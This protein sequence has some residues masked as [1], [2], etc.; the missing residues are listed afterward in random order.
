M[1][2]QQYINESARSKEIRNIYKIPKLL[3][4][5]FSQAWK[6]LMNDQAIYRA[7]VY[8]N[9]EFVIT[10]PRKKGVEKR[11]SPWASK[12]FYNLLLNNLPSWNKMPD[13]DII[14]T[15]ERLEAETRAAGEGGAYFVLPQNGA[16]IGICPREDIW[17][18]FDS[19][20]RIE[21]L[22]RLNNELFNINL[23]D[24]STDDK[25]AHKDWKLFLKLADKL[26]EYKKHDSFPFPLKSEIQRSIFS[27]YLT[28]NKDFISFLD[29]LLDPRKNGFKVKSVGNFRNNGKSEVWTD[30]TCLMIRLDRIY[31]VKNEYES[32]DWA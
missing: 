15:F 32:G 19:H 11:I 8:G 6:Q 4:D 25:I 9:E 21:N 12:N 24:G 23:L 28:N 7:R 30:S 14:C 26:D 18:S 13:R 2:L 1:R 3:K 29:D 20:A 5:K 10:N 31:E 27:D 17:W 22:D 16:K